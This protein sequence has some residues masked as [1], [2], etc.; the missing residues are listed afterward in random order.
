MN[1]RSRLVGFRQGKELRALLR[2]GHLLEVAD[3]CS[4]SLGGQLYRDFIQRHFRD[5]AIRPTKLHG[6]IAQLPLSAR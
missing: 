3:E 1:V 6:L 2:R 4:S 5:P